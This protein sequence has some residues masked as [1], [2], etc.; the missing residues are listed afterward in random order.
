[1]SNKEE[2]NKES[3]HSKET[4]DIYENEVKQQ[5]VFLNCYFCK[6]STGIIAAYIHVILSIGM[7][8][9]NRVIFLHYEFEFDYTL[10][11]LQ[12]LVC[13]IFYIVLSWKSKLFKDKAG[14]LSFRD[15]WKLK[16]KYVGYS[17]FFLIKTLF[18]F[19][20]YQIVKNIP[21]YVNLR[22]LVT[23]MAFIYQYFFKKKK[24]DKIKIVVIILLTIG[25]ILSGID[26]YSTD[27]IGYLVVFCTNA[28][29]VI[30]LEI[31]ENFKKKNGVTN[32]KL[33]AYNGFILPPL[34]LVAMGI[35][36][37]YKG[38]IKYFKAD[39][40]FSYIGL[41]IHLFLS[42]SIVCINMMSFFISNE[43]IKSLLTQL[44]SDSK[45]IF[46][47]LLSYIILKTFEFTWKN[48]LGLIISTIGAII[49]TITS[50][51]D[52]VKFKKQNNVLVNE[53]NIQ[54]SNIGDIGLKDNE[55]NIKNSFETDESTFD[56]NNETK[57]DDNQENNETKIEDSNN[58]KNI[59]IKNNNKENNLIDGNND[60]NI[61]KN[62][63]NNPIS[64]NNNEI[65]DKNNT[66]NKNNN[67]ESIK[68]DKN[69]SINNKSNELII[70]DDNSIINNDI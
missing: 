9:V 21:M 34:L 69:N 64:D 27:Y 51:Y 39:H 67:I 15:F 60:T 49:I 3:D 41:F 46:I 30:N 55:E 32:L 66:N 20:G 13:I 12:Q 62:K 48:I 17:L 16:F 4:N 70:N 59:K 50:M 61:E 25:L 68:N 2:I 56:D 65:I 33:L 23:P 35:F 58:D 5:T 52:N 45:Y 8:I 47:T 26:D 18:A 42:C 53:Q 31:A 22:K 1:M 7:N 29:S 36:G 19:L 6:M 57:I 37:E 11:F 40:D 28:M 38:L 54:L 10:I 63:N 43:K 44:L 24:I 14:E